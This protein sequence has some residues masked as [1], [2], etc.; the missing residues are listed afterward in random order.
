MNNERKS[1]VSVGLTKEE[2]TLLLK[3]SFQQNR[4]VSQV[5][6]FAVKKYLDLITN[7]MES[8]L[9]SHS[10]EDTFSRLAIQIARNADILNAMQIILIEA[11][12]L[13]EDQPFQICYFSDN[14]G[15]ITGYDRFDLLDHDFLQSRIHPD[16]QSESIFQPTRQSKWEKSFRFK[17][18]DGNYAQTRASFLITDEIN[19]LGTWQFI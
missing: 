12:I 7:P 19:L 10:V 5:M 3:T 13:K 9:E 16:D 6:R 18:P 15:K 1:Q 2:K 8:H 4:S 11:K 17:K 14:I